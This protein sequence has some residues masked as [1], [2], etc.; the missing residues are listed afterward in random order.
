MVKRL[1]D[2]RFPPGTRFGAPVPPPPPM[3]PAPPPPEGFMSRFFSSLSGRA[4]REAKAV[5]QE[6]ARRLAEHVRATEAAINAGLPVED[7]K[8]RLIAD[9]EVTE[10]DLRNLAQ[11]SA[12]RVRYYFINVGKIAPDRVFLAKDRTDGPKDPKAATGARVSLGLQ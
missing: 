7:M 2:D 10:D 9:T 12:Q 1:Y 4:E 3:L 5:Q 6:N 8:K 11:A